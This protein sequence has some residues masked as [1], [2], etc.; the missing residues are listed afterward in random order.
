MSL[1]NI[2]DVEMDIQIT[3]DAV[4]C[5]LIDPVEMGLSCAKIRLSAGRAFPPHIHP[6]DHLLI[7]LE[8]DGFL[9]WWGEDGEKFNLSFRF[10][11][12]VP[13]RR[14]LHH[15]VI[16]RNDLVFLAI[17]NPGRILGDPDRMKILPS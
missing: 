1:K 15:S 10:G 17:G 8:G 14:D 16:A 9:S 13:V 5:D 11:D 12:I 2:A 4:G 3:E 6:S 7:I